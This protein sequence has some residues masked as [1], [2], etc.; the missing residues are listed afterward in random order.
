VAIAFI[1][2]FG[3]LDN[4]AGSYI[5]PKAWGETYSYGICIVTK[6]LTIVMILEFTAHLEALNKQA[7]MEGWEEGL[8]KGYRYLS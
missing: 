5:W 4:V 7:E 8:P 2:S 3:Q 6:G 1:N